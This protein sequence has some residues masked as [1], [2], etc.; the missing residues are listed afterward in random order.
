MKSNNIPN[1]VHLIWDIVNVDYNDLVSAII[2]YTSDRRI[3]KYCLHK[4][5]RF[6]KKVNVRVLPEHD[7]KYDDI[8]FD[9]LVSMKFGEEFLEFTNV[10]LSKFYY[11]NLTNFYNNLNEI[12]VGKYDR[13]K[14]KKP[15]SRV[16]L[17][18]YDLKENIIK[19]DEDYAS[20]I[21]FHELFHMASSVYLNGIYYAGFRQYST[22]NYVSI[23]KGLNEGYTQLLTERYFGHNSD[24]GKVYEYEMLIAGK[25][26]KIVGKYKMQELYLN[27]DLYGLIKELK[28]YASYE[29]IINFIQCL[30]FM[31]SNL[32][33][34]KAKLF[35]TNLIIKNIKIINSFLVKTYLVKLKR[36]VS[37][38]IINNDSM[39][40]KLSQYIHSLLDDFHS[41][42]F[43]YYKI[44]RDGIVSDINSIL[45]LVN[46]SERSVHKR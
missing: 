9:T 39:V 17:G 21:I 45:N 8:N 4:K 43:D 13:K 12:K 46:V 10:I 41:V 27:A 1:L 18:Y 7:L 44:S 2:C 30:D 31:N 37:R 26:E 35:R 23:G 15:F 19:L 3:G 24:F 5:P 36:E 33:D 20:V 28:E 42:D 29:D 34:N 14:G 16:M 22:D 25:L 32:N 11:A 38:E 40:I 6:N